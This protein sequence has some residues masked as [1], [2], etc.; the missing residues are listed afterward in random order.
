MTVADI[1]CWGK[2]LR[3]SLATMRK[4]SIPSR[5]TTISVC[6]PVESDRS[7]GDRPCTTITI[8]ALT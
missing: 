5:V 4:A 3:F 7:Y 1:S 8:E 6:A 2:S